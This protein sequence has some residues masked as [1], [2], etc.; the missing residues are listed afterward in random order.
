MRTCKRNK[1][2]R[3]ND[4]SASVLFLSVFGRSMLYPN[5]ISCPYDDESSRLRV[6]FFIIITLC[7]APSLRRRRRGFFLSHLLDDGAGSIQ[8]DFYVNIYHT[9]TVLSMLLMAVG[10]KMR[11]GSRKREQ[12]IIKIVIILIIIISKGSS[13]WDLS[14]NF[15][16]P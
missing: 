6:L 7:L 15:F 16:V 14:L 9:D 1:I 5:Q 10:R 4:K 8:C 11:S 13:C 2:V 12:R 3:K